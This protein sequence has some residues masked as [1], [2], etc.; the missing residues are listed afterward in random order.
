MAYRLGRLRHRT[1]PGDATA[2]ERHWWRRLDGEL[3]DRRH[4]L[5]HLC[6][7]SGWDF[8]RCVARSWN[9]EEAMEAVAGIS[10][11]VLDSIARDLRDGESPLASFRAAMSATSWL[12]DH[13]A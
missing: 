6:E 7:R 2:S 3:I 12:E 13:A 10:L 9:Q 5:S 8:E 11:A 4:V 1:L